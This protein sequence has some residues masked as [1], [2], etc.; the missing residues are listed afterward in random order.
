MS[1]W[2]ISDIIPYEGTKTL[3]EYN[4]EVVIIELSDINAYYMVTGYLDLSNMQSDN[5]ILVKEYI[6]LAQGTY[7]K[8]L[9]YR[10]RGI[11]TDPIVMV[12]PKYLTPNDRYKL[13]LVLTG[14]SPI[15]IPY[16]LLLFKYSSRE[17]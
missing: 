3:S 6:D 7:K 9:S 5:E 12:T 2:Y 1:V 8:Y 14:G 13:V 15:D 11:Q 17:I 10:F 4:A 16:K